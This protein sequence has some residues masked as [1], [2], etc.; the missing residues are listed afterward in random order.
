MEEEHIWIQH[1]GPRMSNKNG[2]RLHGEG[3]R[4]A[5]ENGGKVSKV[6]YQPPTQRGELET[7]TLGHPTIFFPNYGGRACLPRLDR[8]LS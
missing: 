3:L 5:F 8:E 2:E 4:E 7:D 1:F 6:G